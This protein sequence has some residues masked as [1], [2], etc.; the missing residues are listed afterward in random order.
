MATNLP[1]NG[2]FKVTNPYR[3]KGDWIAGFHTGIDLFGITNKDVYSVCEGKVIMVDQNY[4]DYGKAVKV[5]DST[6]GKI[7]LF[8]HLK[9][10]AV[11]LNQY[12][13][14][15]TKIGVMGNSGRSTGPHLHI[16]MRT[17]ADKYGVVE[18]IAK[19]MGIPNKLGIYNSKDYPIDKSVLKYEVHIEKIGWQSPRENGEIAG[20]EGEGLRLEAI[21]INTNIPIKYRVHVENIGWMDWVTNGETAGTIGESKRVECIEIECDT[22]K[23]IGTA[24]VQN[25][26]WKKIVVG[27]NIKIGT[28][29]KALRLE[30]LTLKFVEI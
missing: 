22:K 28:E 30:A 20:T 29:G 27:N 26:G 18:D 8:A 2:E 11:K 12:V 4:G 15:L 6:T 13:S 5:K 24:H 25:E 19:Y 1:F 9:S 16:E 7:F 10:I 21:I 14:R 23:I 17:A 3:K